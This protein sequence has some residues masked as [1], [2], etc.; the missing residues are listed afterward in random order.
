MVN[1]ILETSWFAYPALMASNLSQINVKS[2][3]LDALLA[4]MVTVRNVRMVLGL[5]KTGTN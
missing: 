1:V 4:R 2:A 3:H 5:L